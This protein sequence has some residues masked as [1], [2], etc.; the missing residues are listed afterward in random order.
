ML[1]SRIRIWVW[2][3][4]SLKAETIRTLMLVKSELRLGYGCANKAHCRRHLFRLHLR[5]TST[6]GQPNQDMDLLSEGTAPVT[7][8]KALTVIKERMMVKSKGNPKKRIPR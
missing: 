8:D 1:H 5:Q 2:H 7:A 3:Y 6:S 4:A